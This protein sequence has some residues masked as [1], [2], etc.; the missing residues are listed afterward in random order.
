MVSASA[1]QDSL[2]ELQLDTLLALTPAHS[3]PVE[4]NYSMVYILYVSAY[5]VAGYFL[6]YQ[7]P[8]HQD[9]LAELQLDTL[10]ALTPAHSFPADGNYSMVYILYVSAYFGGWLLSVVSASTYQDS[11]AEPQLDTLLALTPAH[12]YPADGN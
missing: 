8:D 2:A 9:S 11:L 1:Y 7:P 4:G 12:S 6:W 10:L 5:L 3:F